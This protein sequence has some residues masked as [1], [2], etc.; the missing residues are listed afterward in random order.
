MACLP[1][2]LRRLVPSAPRFMACMRHAHTKAT[3]P[4]FILDIDG[5]M[6]RGDVVLKEGKE[7][8]RL[9]ASNSSY[10]YNNVSIMED[11]T[12]AYPLLDVMEK[13]KKFSSKPS[14]EMDPIDAVFV[15][16]DPLKWETQLQVLVD[17]MTSNGIPGDTVS[18][19]VIPIYFTNPDF[20]WA[21]QHSQMRF[22]Q[23]AFKMCLESLYMGYTGTKLNSVQFGK[24]YPTT[25]NYA[26]EELRQ[27][28]NNLGSELG[29]IY[30]I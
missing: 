15:M 7:A 13:F 16:T 20:L 18:K 5:V 3:L 25:Y 12:R 2:I 17:I 10:G 23:G 6:T 14:R 4:G 8:M 29:C 28:A 11:V 26:F 21:A 27:Q 19:Q 22:G 9:L 1:A 30:G 24:P